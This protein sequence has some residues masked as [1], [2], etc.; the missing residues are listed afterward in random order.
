M[1]KPLIK[2]SH[3]LQ[4][5]HCKEKPISQGLKLSG[6]PYIFGCIISNVE[7]S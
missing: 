1:T 5:Q 2:L 4:S 3:V 7:L 6:D